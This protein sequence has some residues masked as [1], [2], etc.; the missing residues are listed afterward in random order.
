MDI[1][2][3]GGSPCECSITSQGCR[4]LQG[5]A[6]PWAW[7]RP[8]VNGWLGLVGGGKQAEQPKILVLSPNSNII[9]RLCMTQI[10]IITFGDDFFRAVC[11]L[12]DSSPKGYLSAIHPWISPFSFGSQALPGTPCPSSPAELQKTHSSVPKMGLVPSCADSINQ[13]PLIREFRFCS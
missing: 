11:P 13:T 4:C 6:A 5:V 9:C 8:P 2:P 12:W 1:F 7:E 10:R 3:R